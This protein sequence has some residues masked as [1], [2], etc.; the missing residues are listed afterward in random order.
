MNQ[1]A[2]LSKYRTEKP[3][4]KDQVTRLSMSTPMRPMPGGYSY[5]GAGKDGS[6]TSNKPV[7][8][9]TLALHQGETVIPAQ[10]TAAAGGPEFVSNAVDEKIMQKKQ[11]MPNVMRADTGMMGGMPTAEYKKKLAAQNANMT[12]TTPTDAAGRMAVDKG[13]ALSRGLI[14]P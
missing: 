8:M 13:D 2:W 14:N 3:K 6:V 1:P 5:M 4:P 7:M 11:D 10:K 12:E 9:D